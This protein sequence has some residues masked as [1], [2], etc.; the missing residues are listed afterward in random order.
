MVEQDTLAQLAREAHELFV[1]PSSKDSL[2]APVSELIPKVPLGFAQGAEAFCSNIRS[3]VSMAGIPYIFAIEAS[4][5][6]RYQ[7]LYCAAE[8]QAVLQAQ[9]ESKPALDTEEFARVDAEHRMREL[10]ESATG[11]NVL[12]HDACQLLLSFGKNADVADAATQLVLQATVL[13]WA[14]LKC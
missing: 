5:G 14:P 7:L 3:L 12:N 8:L 2:L 13:T 10:R 9:D 1:I 4:H 11:R 6:R